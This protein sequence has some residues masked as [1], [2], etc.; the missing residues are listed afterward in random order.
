MSPVWLRHEPLSP[1]SSEIQRAENLTS[2]DPSGSKSE[3]YDHPEWLWVGLIMRIWPWSFSA[4][5]QIWGHPNSNTLVFR[6]RIT[7]EGCILPGLAERTLTCRYSGTPPWILLKFESY[8][9]LG[10]PSRVGRET[11]FLSWIGKKSITPE[12]YFG[13]ILNNRAALELNITRIV[14]TIFTSLFFVFIFCL[15][16][17]QKLQ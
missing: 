2:S 3:F 1:W 8:I 17:G 15:Q 6:D 13:F 12:T 10:E 5:R 14:H 4:V 11:N 16:R 9:D 7:L